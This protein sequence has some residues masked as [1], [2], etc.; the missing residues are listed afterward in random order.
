MFQGKLNWYNTIYIWFNILFHYSEN[1][2]SVVF[3]ID[4]ILDDSLTI[5]TGPTSKIQISELVPW[6]MYCQQSVHI[7]RSPR[8]T[9]NHISFVFSYENGKAIL[10]LKN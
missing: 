4:W 6:N 5:S 2:N 7:F 3:W 9:N 10:K 8:P 1:S